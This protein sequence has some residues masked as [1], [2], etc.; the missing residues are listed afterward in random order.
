MTT[1]EDKHAEHAR[2][3]RRLDDLRRAQPMTS[4]QYGV[5]PEGIDDLRKQVAECVTQIQAAP[6]EARELIELTGGPLLG[7]TLIVGTIQDT[8]AGPLIALR[9]PGG[10]EVGHFSRGEIDAMTFTKHG[11]WS[12]KRDVPAMG[13]EVLV[14]MNSLGPATVLKHQVVKGWLGLIVRFH[15]P[16]EWYLRQNRGVSRPG[17]VFGAEIS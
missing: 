11:K 5:M 15:Q 3:V 13:S 9:Q 16:P 14:I 2:L 12:G 6:L 17:L 10:A 4:A 7:Q 1:Y 8:E